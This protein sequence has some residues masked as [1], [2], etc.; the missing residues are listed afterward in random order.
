MRT[1]LKF[2]GS[3]F[4]R[5]GRF[6]FLGTAVVGALIL[7]PL[8]GIAAAVPSFDAAVA[9]VNPPSAKDSSVQYIVIN[10]NPLRNESVSVTGTTTN[11]QAAANAA[12]PA[13]S[14]FTP[15]QTKADELT[16]ANEA[17]SRSRNAATS[18]GVALDDITRHLRGFK[19]TFDSTSATT[20]TQ[21]TS[22]DL[23][24]ALATFA[25]SGAQGKAQF[26]AAPTVQQAAA[27]YR[28]WTVRNVIGPRGTFLINA[29]STLN[30]FRTFAVV[31]ERNEN[32]DLI[33]DI[34]AT[35]GGLSDP[36]FK[37]KLA[38]AR[39][40][41][42]DLDAAS[43]S[44][45]ATAADN[46]ANQ[47]AG[48][49]SD[50]SQL[51]QIVNAPC[52]ALGFKTRSY[53]IKF[54]RDKNTVWEEDVTCLPEF[55]V[56]AMYYV[57]F[58]NTDGYSLSSSMVNGAA[59]SVVTKQSNNRNQGS[60]AAVVH[61]CPGDQGPNAWCGS[62]AGSTSSNGLDIFV[63]GG[64]LFAHRTFGLHGGLHLGQI[65]VLT[66]GYSL[67]SVVPANATFTRK[68]LTA[69]PFVGLTVNVK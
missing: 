11:T 44:T 43:V 28:D 62:V 23:T 1:L 34:A 13:K 64:Y 51:Y 30:A 58:L 17:R 31:Q 41:L 19:A 50:P 42:K 10:L 33:E 22:G 37:S 20:L 27:I 54:L 60:L 52:E 40:A 18:C 57:D 4:T 25:T 55:Q 24:N 9:T 53:V 7:G 68:Q 26:D 69:A 8:I 15:S 47:I 5:R 63:G 6:L 59:A 32:S 29:M 65:N 2:L 36:A 39:A 48:I 14:T 38:E 45:V 67:G 21:Q 49:Q 16:C 66:N 12:T 3:R 61:W 35:A 46:V 56:G